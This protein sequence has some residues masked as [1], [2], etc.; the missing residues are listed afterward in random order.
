[1][2]INE[3]KTILLVE[4]DALIAMCEAQMLRKEGYEVLLA[5]SGEEAITKAAA[6]GINLILMDIDL[7][8][9]RLDGTQ[10]AQ[11][12]L[13]EQDIP[14]VFLSSHTEPEV[15][16]KTEKI[17]SYGYVV[18]NTGITVLATSIKMAFK[19]HA[20]NQAVRQ[21]NEH[22]SRE[23]AARQK[24][25]DELRETNERY[26]YT[27]MVGK[28]GTWDWDIPG[29][30]LIWSDETFRLLGLP[31]GSIVPD[32]AFFLERVHPDDRGLVDAN[33]KAAW[34]QKKPYSLDSRM[35]QAG[36][37]EI[38]CHISG[39][40]EF[41]A[42]DRPIRMLGTIQDIT[43]RKQAEDA[44][45]ASESRNRILI[46]EMST[47]FALHELVCDAAGNPV[48]YI[49]LDVNKT[50]EVQLNVPREA[51]IGARASD[52]LPPEELKHWLGI[53]GPVA[54]TGQ[55]ARYQI[56]SS[57]NDKHFE[58]SAF[59]PARGQ[60]AVTFMDVTERRRAEEAL[61]VSE[62][63]FAAAFQHSPALMTI[64]SIEDGKY[65]SVNDEFARVS[66]FCRE[67]AI[68]K[69][70]IELGWLRSDDR[71]RLIET[72]RTQGRVSRMEIQLHA[73]DG[74]V[75]E[76]LY[77]GEIISVEG[78]PYLLSLAE[79]ITEHKRTEEALRESE[80]KFAR[81]FQVSPAILCIARAEDQHFVE[82]NDAMLRMTG[83]TREEII[84]HSA[85]ELGFWV[86]PADRTEVLQTLAKTGQVTNREYLFRI[87]SGKILFCAYSAYMIT[88]GGKRYI[89][90]HIVDLTEYKRMEEALQDERRMFIGGPTVVFKRI[91]EAGWPVEYVSPNVFKQFGYSVEAFTSR[92]VLFANIIHPA[93]LQRVGEEVAR[94]NQAG[95]AWF[96]QKYRILRADGQVR[97][98]HDFT[99]V[100]RNE[101][102][103][104]TS[105]WGYVQ[106]I[107]AQKQA[108]DELRKSQALYQ[109]LFDQIGDG[110]LILNTAGKLLSVNQAF[111]RL[112]GYSVE[113]MLAMGL[114]KL[115]VEGM[116]P[117]P[118]RLRRILAGETLTFE[119]EHIHKDRSTF[120]LE[121]TANLVTVGDE[122]LIVATH[123]NITERKRAEEALRQSQARYQLVFE[124]SGT[125]NAIFDTA[126]RLVMQNSLS[127]RSLGVKPGE[128]LGKSARELFGPVQG[129]QIT[130]RMQHVLK[131]GE[132]QAFDTQF[133]L[134][135]GKQW[136]HST[137]QALI[138]E[139][140]AIQGIQIISQ[141][142]TERKQIEEAL[143]ESETKFRAIFE[144]SIDAVGVSKMGTHIFVNS[145]YLNLFGYTR[146]EELIGRSILDLIAPSCHEQII[147]NIRSRAAG[148]DVPAFYETRGLRK[149]GAEFEM[150]VHI[151]TYQLQNEVFTV[152]HLRD[153]TQRKQ[154]EE[155]LLLIRAAVESSSN[156]IGIS[157]IH[158]RHF[159][160]NKALSDLF[161]YA[162]AEEL[163]A[164]GGGPA[165]VKDPEVA[166]DMFAAI[167]SGR[168]WIG[169]LEM[170]AKDG[171]VFPAFE[172]A[173]VIK[174]DAGEVIGLIG[175]IT[176]FT[177]RK[178]T[179][180]KLRQ[181]LAE[182]EMLLRE[183]QHRVKNSLA[184]VASLLHLEEDNLPD[185]RSRLIFANTKSRIHSMSIIYEQFY[186]GGG[187]DQVDLRLYIRNLVEMLSQSYLPSGGRVSIEMQLD[188]LRLDVKRAWSLGLILNELITNALK[189][190]FPK[191]CAPGGQAGI[192]LVSLTRDDRQAALR[193]ADNGIGKAESLSS[194]GSGMGLSLVDM[195]S[196][197]IGGSFSS[198]S[199]AGYAA[200]VKFSL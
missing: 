159:Y 82:A 142:I 117:F 104:I 19:L 29:D 61:R 126:C 124:N 77:N 161:G 182:K 179:E 98:L 119:V 75:I 181:M 186:R 1:M 175:T 198:E 3:R 20:A 94:H 64:S 72:L 193:V 66:G 88:F 187:I 120:L 116:G 50:F 45:R 148:K 127:A 36:G 102:G 95:S 154:L 69:T 152:G 118:E 133:D 5:G 48:D 47:G 129:P 141:N 87:K 122:P 93:D 80:E 65:L 13:K 105:Y 78:Q 106:D 2:S 79:D 67:E 31:P 63:K 143:R 115:D 158:G 151:S 62:G 184:M 10:A 101:N 52:I 53:F 196:R 185:E 97:W 100:K 173:N 37:Q 16:A 90:V 30:A 121:V 32:Y 35:I 81:T 140:G 96:E 162:T 176:D 165:A 46:S 189:Y 22:L 134:P 123:R 113:E 190:A 73:K 71:A 58:G 145:A 24:V 59:C 132:A 103:A 180:E 84:G 195:L 23:I 197:Q 157:D 138:D 169:E 112:H 191:G 85:D 149:D 99:S 131:T 74:R 200:Q 44:L 26:D 12:I 54:L 25:E 192:I 114:K 8:W 188:E 170:V 178:Q 76:C 130:E 156:A 125:T 18:K 57:F 128:A 163:Q 42:D 39:K 183:L 139:Q 155:R 14:V 160:Q 49:T 107:T 147:Q 168:P 28:V 68:G 146:P 164:V 70:S 11:E 167:Q 199:R 150:D 109:A 194:S 51:V 135:G 55:S 89:F 9:G 15:V 34:Y 174:N 83:Y 171:R 17:T 108:E 144:N 111:A 172:V 6:G 166:R 137:Y 91:A 33:V 4:D 21:T 41:A 177:E 153:I 7:G 110:V 92:E 56:Y 86:N 43:E 27:T 136:Y 60:F 38:V 40:V